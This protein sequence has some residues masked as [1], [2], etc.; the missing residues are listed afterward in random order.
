MPQAKGRVERA[1]LTLQDRLVKEL[2]L[3]IISTIEKTKDFVP[4]CLEDFKRRFAVQPRS[5]HDV[6]RSLLYS[7]DELDIIFSRQEMRIL[8]K[9]LTLQYNRV[10]YQIQTTR[11]TYALRKAHVTVCEHTQG[12]IAIFCKGKSLSYSILNKHQR[13]ADVVMSKEID[14]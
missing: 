5:S 3:Q 7:D 13:Q 9:I 12:E 10:I 4:A 1:N 6:H 2:R 11:P 14:T 8:S